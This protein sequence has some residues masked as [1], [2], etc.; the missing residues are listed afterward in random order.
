MSNQTLVEVDDG[1]SV[2]FWG[3]SGGAAECGMW[4]QV[5][6]A[7]RKADGSTEVWI[8]ERIKREPVLVA[9]PPTV[10]EGE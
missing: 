3:Y 1:S 8:Y 7:E 5:T 10:G 4:G 2:E 9:H 6:L